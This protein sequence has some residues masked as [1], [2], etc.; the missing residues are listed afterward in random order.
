MERILLKQ[1]SLGIQ[2]LLNTYTGCVIFIKNIR[3]VK[4]ENRAKYY[5]CS[6]LQ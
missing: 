3:D 2:P 1:K 5:F 6:I 4:K